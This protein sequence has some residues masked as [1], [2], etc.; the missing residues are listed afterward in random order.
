MGKTEHPLDGLRVAIR[1]TDG[2]EQIELTGPRRALEHAGADTYLVAPED[3]KIRGWNHTDWGDE[4]EVD[5]PLADADPDD[6]D[7]L[8]LPGGVTRRARDRF[9]AARGSPPPS[10]SRRARCPRRS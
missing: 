6:F 3:G 5:L 7:A 4:L 8:L 10:D 1:A 9:A 2:F